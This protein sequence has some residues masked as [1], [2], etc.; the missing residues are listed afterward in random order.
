[1]TSTR[2]Y[3]IRAFYDWIVDNDF[4]PYIVINTTKHKVDV[5]SQYVHDG[6]IVFNISASVVRSLTIS[7]AEIMFEAR[8]SGVSRHIYAPIAAVSAIYA[9]ENGRGMVFED[10][11][12][13]GGGP[14][15]PV[16]ATPAETSKKGKPKLTVIK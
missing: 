4:T 6:K 11:E 14:P 15:P 13:D 9:R 5:P 10:E 7:N 3:L 12:E 1:M 2:P 8:F 16:S